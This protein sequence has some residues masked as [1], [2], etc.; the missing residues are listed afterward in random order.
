MATITNKD[1]DKIDLLIRL[2]DLSFDDLK[3]LVTWVD[4]LDECPK[5]IK[6]LED[7]QTK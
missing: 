7:G 6:D 5:T 2:N 4:Y 3:K 1:L